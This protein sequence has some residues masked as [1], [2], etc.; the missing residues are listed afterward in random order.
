MVAS[1]HDNMF[2]RKCI[3][4]IDCFLDILLPTAVRHVAGMDE[5]VSG[6][7]GRVVAV[8][9]RDAYYADRRPGVR[10]CKGCAPEASEDVVEKGD[11][12][13]EG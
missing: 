8:R 9:V 7:N 4:P 1:N 3:Q 11:D 12:E 13:G 2:M 10:R 5:Q 6:G